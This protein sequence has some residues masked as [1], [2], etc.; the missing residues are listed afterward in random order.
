MSINNH[1]NPK[2]FEILEKETVYAG[3]FQ[4]VRYRLRYTLF[5]GGWS[6]EVVREVFE[7][8]H[9]ASVLLY[10]PILDKVVM[11]E[12]FRVGAIRADNESPKMWL[13]EVVAGIIEPGETTTEVVYREAQEEAGCTVSD[14]ILMYDYLVSPGGTT[15][16]NVMFCGRVDA[17]QAGGIHGLAHEQED[18]K[19]HVLSVTTALDKLH[20]GQIC[21][22]PAIIALQWLALHKEEVKQRWG[23]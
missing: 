14:L 3:Y 2:N 18:I 22:A 8:G 9:A 12:Q 4:I 10:D 21:S 13:W 5:A 16:S 7:R 1:T 17:S 19:V 11:I 15:E 6:D 20:D 23:C